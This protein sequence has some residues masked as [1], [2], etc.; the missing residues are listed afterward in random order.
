MEDKVTQENEVI[1]L[2]MHL[3]EQWNKRSAAGMSGVFAANGSLVGFD[4]S[5]LNSQK[6]IYDVLVEIFDNFPTASYVAIV[7]EVRMLGDNVAMVRSVVGM[8]PHGE[9]D[10]NPA[11]N[12]IQ[13]TIAVKDNGEWRIAL[14]QNT[15]AAFHGRPEVSELL[16]A[17]L[18]QALSMKN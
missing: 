6:E 3:L 2:Y 10:I 17:D 1:A 14:F 5:Q 7:K 8:V 11:V 13:S 4:G 16:S 9:Q 12:A 15:P 18:R